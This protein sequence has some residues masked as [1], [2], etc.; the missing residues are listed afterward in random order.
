MV[1]GGV[2]NIKTRIAAGAQQV[3]ECYTKCNYHVTDDYPT[4]YVE[5]LC[6]GGQPAGTLVLVVGD[7]NSTTAVATAKAAGWKVHVWTWEN[8]KKAYSQF[9]DISLSFLIGDYLTYTA[10][11]MSL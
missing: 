6:S 2:D 11:W 7:T 4:S 1:E 9:V 3:A 8:C 10:V 5:S